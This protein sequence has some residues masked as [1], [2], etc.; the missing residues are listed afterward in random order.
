[1]YE[2]RVLSVW[3]IDH[4]AEC[5]KCDKALLDRRRRAK[6]EEIGHRIVEVMASSNADGP[7]RSVSRHS[8]SQSR[9]R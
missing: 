9:R 6:I 7:L 8:K 4:I 1:M 3:G 2:S 5:T